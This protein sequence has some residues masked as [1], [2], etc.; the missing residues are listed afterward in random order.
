MK[1]DFQATSRTSLSPLVRLL[2]VLLVFGFSGCKDQ[3]GTSAS[4]QNTPETA[5]GGD[6]YWAQLAQSYPAFVKPPELLPAYPP[7]QWVSFGRWDDTID[8]PL[9][10]TGAANLPDGRIVAWSSQTPNAFGGPSE[11]TVGTIFNPANGSFESTPN[12]TH[13]MFCAGVSMLEDGR[14]FVAGGGRTVSTTSVFDTDQFSEIEPMAMSRWYPTSTTLATGQVFTSL[15]TTIAP[16]PE[17][18]T[19]GKGWSLIPEIS[20]Q[21]ILDSGDV[22]HNDWYPAFNVAPDGSLFHPGHMPDILSVYLDQKNDVHA[23]HDH[24]DHGHDEESR[25]YN[26]TVMYD[27]GKLLVAGGGAGDNATNTDR[28]TDQRYEACT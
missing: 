13:D 22:V 24:D 10:A 21:P 16:Y 1:K 27:I 4:G 25:L 19:D 26:T 8:W 17:I 9:I 20:L 12:S 23:H 28:H 2:V 18:W 5:Q 11:S 15:G 7:D 14:I 3:Q 6:D